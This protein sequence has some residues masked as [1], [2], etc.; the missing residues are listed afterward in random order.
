MCLPSRPV[1][2]K[3]MYVPS[4]SVVI[5]LMT[6]PSRH[7]KKTLYICTYFISTHTPSPVEKVHTTSL[8]RPVQ[9]TT[10]SKYIFS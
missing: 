3:Y 6:V 9:P 5:S 1:E 4:R 8:F 7:Q 2:E 10:T